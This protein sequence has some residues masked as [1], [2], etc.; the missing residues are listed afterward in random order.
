MSEVVT[1][2]AEILQTQTSRVMPARQQPP[3][4]SPSSPTPQSEPVKLTIENCQAINIHNGFFVIRGSTLFQCAVNTAY[5]IR[6]NT[7][8]KL[9]RLFFNG[10]IVETISKEMPLEYLSANLPGYFFKVVD[11]NDAICFNV[12]MLS[13]IRFSETPQKQLVMLFSNGVPMTMAIN[14]VTMFTRICEMMEYIA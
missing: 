12:R 3:L 14:D 5:I 9:L 8:T 4:P 7:E 10:I 13:F 1:G 6:Y 11:G 2:T